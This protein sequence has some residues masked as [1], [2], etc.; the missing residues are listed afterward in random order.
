MDRGDFSRPGDVRPAQELI[1]AGKRSPDSGGLSRNK[2]GAQIA[3]RRWWELDANE[4]H[5]SPGLGYREIGPERAA[6]AFRN[7]GPSK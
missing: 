4:Y 3:G 2:N 5:P 1:S 7:A 6:G